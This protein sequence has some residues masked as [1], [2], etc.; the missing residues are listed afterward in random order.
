MEPWKLIVCRDIHD[1]VKRHVLAS[2]LVKVWVLSKVTAMFVPLKDLCLTYAMILGRSEQEVQTER[3]CRRE[4][5]DE[6]VQTRGSL[7]YE[8]CQL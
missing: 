3:G 4:V 7:T 5:A 8:I 2:T 6:R 1:I